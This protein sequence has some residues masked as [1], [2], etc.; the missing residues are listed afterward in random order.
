MKRIAFIFAVI[1]LMIGVLCAVLPPFIL[2]GNITAKNDNYAIVHNDSEYHLYFRGSYRSFNTK[3]KL[4]NDGL[5]VAAPSV[6]FASFAEMKSDIQSGNFSKSEMGNIARF[7]RNSQGYVQAVNPAELYEP[8]FPAAFELDLSY[9]TW[10]GNGYSVVYN[11]QDSEKT[12]ANVLFWSKEFFEKEVDRLFTDHVQ[13]LKDVSSNVNIHYVTTE[14]SRNATIV[15]YTSSA[16]MDFRT[17]LYSINKNGK[18][19]YIMETY[20]L[21]NKGNDFFKV[22]EE[23]PHK[24]DIYCS[25][26]GKYFLASLRDLSARPTMEELSAVGLRKYVETEV[27]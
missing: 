2:D 22:S 7:K 13:S 20:C 4:N 8:F 16:G 19:L 1:I 25:E 15:Q 24:V 11:W 12:E 18:S 9:I 3:P 23:T 27:S 21:D 26:H 5:H 17:I 6:K 14:E 10:R